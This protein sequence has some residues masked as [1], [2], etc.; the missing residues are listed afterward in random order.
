M[1]LY[2]LCDEWI[3]TSLN[4]RCISAS[5]PLGHISNSSFALLSEKPLAEAERVD[6]PCIGLK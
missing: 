3:T 4:G 2:D 6:A 1:H 5:N